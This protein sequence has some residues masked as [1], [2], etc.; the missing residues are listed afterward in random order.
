MG[1]C[2]AQHLARHIRRLGL[3]YYVAECAAPSLSAAE[4]SA[5]GFEV[6]SARYGNIYTVRQAV[7]LF[8]R[9]FGAFT[10]ADAVWQKD[11][12]FVDAFRPQIE[13]QP[14][15]SV[16]DVQ[17]SAVEHL[18][19]VRDVFLKSSWIVFTLGLTEAW[20]SK[21]DGAVYPIA[22]GVSGGT[23][24]P[25]KYAFVNFGVD[26][27]RRDLFEL[28]DKI[29]EVNPACRILLT[30][31]P[32]PLI[33][34]YGTRHVWTATTYSKAVLRI[35]A[36]EAERRYSHVTYFPSYEVITSPAA[37]GRYYADDLRQVTELGVEHVMRL[38]E[39]H[40]VSQ[41]DAGS[42]T[43]KNA[44]EASA[45]S[46]PDVV[47]DEEVIEESLARAGFGAA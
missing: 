39:T 38:F 33:A 42:S 45:W 18:G 7:Q 24:R 21:L 43:S 8:D 12:G 20:Q 1:S 36:D 2:F 5:R 47:C 3:T 34:T 41:S 25:D 40:Y 6:F 22:P 11:E 26:D 13:P 16:D 15:A 44:T 32:V 35:A 27:V 10:P 23:F 19:Y 14:F 28:I 37:G 17:G 4:A 30:V 29:H 9:S 46:R 31:S